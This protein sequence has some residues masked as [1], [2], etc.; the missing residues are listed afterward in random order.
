MCSPRRRRRVCCRPALGRGDCARAHNEKVK[1]TGKGELQDLRPTDYD[2]AL[3][4]K[5]YRGFEEST[6]EALEYLGQYFIY[7][8]VNAQ[9]D[10]AAVEANIVREMEYQS[11]LEL[12]PETH[13]M[14]HD[15]PRA[16]EAIVHARDKCLSNDLTVTH[17]RRQVSSSL[18]FRF[19]NQI[20]TRLLNA[21]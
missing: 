2:P 16:D 6:F 12:N 11:S 9:G 14:I 5:R 13:D 7:N 8:F 20:A 3:A 10:F 15:L 18:L 19:S 21:T 17:R 1:A 4:A